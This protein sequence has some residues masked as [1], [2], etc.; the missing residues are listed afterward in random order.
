VSAVGIAV[1]HPELHESMSPPGRIQR[2]TAST[3]KIRTGKPTSCCLR[4]DV[5]HRAT[6]DQLKTLPGQGGRCLAGLLG[7]LWITTWP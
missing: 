3:R 7:R 4:R 5:D 1:R 2:N 6:P